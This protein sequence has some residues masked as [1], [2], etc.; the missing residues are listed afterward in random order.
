MFMNENSKLIRDHFDMTD[1]YTRKYVATL[2]DAGQEQLLSALSSALYDKIVSKVDKIDFGSI[3]NS[4]GDI[5][6]V[7]GFNNT[8]QCLSIIRRLVIEYKQSPEIVDVI[9]T[10]IENIKSRKALFIKAYSLN[11]ELPMMIYNLIVLAIERSVSL[12]IATCIEYVKDSTSPNMKKAL[13]KAAYQNTMDDMLFQ[14][15]L[16]F[17]NQCK[18]GNI[19]KVIDSA[20]KNPV[21]ES[22]DAESYDTVITPVRDKSPV[23]DYKPAD[24]DLPNDSEVPAE[25][26]APNPTLPDVEDGEIVPSPFGDSDSIE[27]PDPEED[28]HID[29]SEPAESID[30]VEDDTGAGSVIDYD[31]AAKEP[32]EAEPECGGATS[33]CQNCG[34]DPCTCNPDDQEVDIRLSD[35]DPAEREFPEEVPQTPVPDVAST[36]DTPSEVPTGDFYDRLKA[37]LAARG[38]DINNIMIED[39]PTTAEDN[40]VEPENVPTV[41]PGDSISSDDTSINEDEVKEGVAYDAAKAAAKAIGNTKIGTTII[42]KGP[43]FMKAVGI[44]AAIAL[45]IYGIPK[46]IIGFVIPMLRTIVYYFYYTQMKVSDYLAIQAELIESEAEESENEEA[47]AKQKKWA[48]RL[49]NWSNKFNIDN[50]QATNKANNDVKKD[51]KEKAKVKKNN[52][53]E[54]VLF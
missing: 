17:N 38:I 9:I 4:R 11:V 32:T 37:K 26:P 40:N 5:T 24:S 39:E 54:D 7:E 19:D 20:F 16:V 48:E 30:S 31:T 45:A 42:T 6:K 33:V 8:E 53:G 23:Q 35:E 43:K 44:A 3:P 2:E 15:L 29:D 12:M 50:K 41:K 10:A 14:Q 46:L 1:N 28:T 34:N 18:N 13:D 22:V 51:N 25:S 21:K 36:V 49:R 47:A 52:D 27:N